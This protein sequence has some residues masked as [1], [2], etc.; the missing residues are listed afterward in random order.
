MISVPVAVHSGLFKW[1]LDL[2]WHNHKLTYG[3][4]A[5]DKALAIVVKRNKPHENKIETLKW[6]IDIPHVMCESFFDYL[7]P[8]PN[9][10]NVPLNIQTG[11]KQI[12][13]RFSDDQ[14]IEVMLS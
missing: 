7:T 12:I 9:E 3:E 8:A 11:L 13:D 5:I 2:F 14:I 10:K 6:D 1:Q 4:S